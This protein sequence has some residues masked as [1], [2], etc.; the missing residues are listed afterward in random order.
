MIDDYFNFANDTINYFPRHM[1]ASQLTPSI[2]AAS[3]TSLTVL[4]EQPI[5]NT[6][7][8][9][10]DLLAWGEPTAP[11]SQM[12]NLD[13]STDSVTDSTHN[14]NNDET[15]PEIRQAIHEL[16][17]ANG[18]GE[19]LTQRC[20]TGML[21]SFP[22]ECISQASSVLLKLFQLFPAASAQWTADTIT[23][24]PVGSVVEQ[25]RD[26]LRTNIAQRIE[27]Q[28]IGK[29][30]PLLQDF[31][32]AFRRRNVAPREGLGRLEGGRFRFAG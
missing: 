15:P 27:S 8:F 25:E 16:V 31:C 2:L 20:L 10:H 12:P 5:T 19:T 23:L 30:R 32:S 21:Y 24:L 6:L 14:R 4:K 28:E 22:E 13:S 1:L 9:L 26:R 29:V 3:C 18:F 7:H 17:P 11:I